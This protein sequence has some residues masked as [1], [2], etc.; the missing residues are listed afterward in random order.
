MVV[1]SLLIVGIASLFGPDSAP[2]TGKSIEGR[3]AAEAESDIEDISAPPA[4][5]ATPPAETAAAAAPELST[6][7]MIEL[8]PAAAIPFPISLDPSDAVPE[9]SSVI[10]GGLPEG[11][12]LSA[13][14]PVGNGEWNLA[15]DEIGNLAVTVPPGTTGSHPVR[16]ALID[17]QGGVLSDASTTLV[18][19][20][21]AAVT[22]ADEAGDGE[23]DPFSAQQNQSSA[24]P[25]ETASVEGETQTSPGA[26]PQPS[27]LGQPAD[28]GVAG[29]ASDGKW[30]VVTTAV[31]M[32]AKPASDGQ[33]V[34][35]QPKGKRLRVTE[36]QYGW[37]KVTD[38]EGG[39]GGWIYKNFLKDAE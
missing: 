26:Q 27:S 6:A 17:A 21:E 11:A 37:L 18:V 39:Q 12:S 2:E 32:R 33:T 31:N 5:A 36:N 29:A 20:G 28:D 24:D 13:G 19:R 30:M 23:Q 9:R 4:E 25:V 35:V 8:A 22:A 10:I 1:L 15:A 34:I 38:P 3:F 14:R 7:S 16:V